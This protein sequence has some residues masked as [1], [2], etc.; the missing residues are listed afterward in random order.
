[1]DVANPFMMTARV[2]LCAC[3]LPGKVLIQNILHFNSTYG[4]GLCEQPGKNLHTENGGNIR[5]FP[6][7]TESPK[8]DTKTEDACLQ[9]AKEAVENNSVVNTSFMFVLNTVV[10]H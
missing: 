1:M 10:G 5:I 9:Y 7:Q 2:I 3:D 4:C 6:Y 8:G